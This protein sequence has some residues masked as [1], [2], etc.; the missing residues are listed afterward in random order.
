MCRNGRKILD[1]F[2]RVD[3][4]KANGQKKLKPMISKLKIIKIRVPIKM[5]ARAPRIKRRNMWVC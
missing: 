1:S 5:I 2:R 3:R 4:R